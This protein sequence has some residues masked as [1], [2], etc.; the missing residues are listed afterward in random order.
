MSDHTEAC[1]ESKALCD[2]L[3][4]HL[5]RRIPN[6]KRA[7]TTR[8][9]G[10]YQSD[11]TRFGYI[12]HRKNMSR[13][14]VWCLGDPAELQSNSSLKIIPREE[15]RG[16]W[17]KGFQARF[18]VDDTSQIDPACDVMYQVS[19]RLSTGKRRGIS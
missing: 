10:L 17:G 3:Y 4:E 15:T 12:N 2:K 13:I 16:G 6:L 1:Q 7:Q 14:E 9:C 18:F 19:Y 5:S 8:W 11:K